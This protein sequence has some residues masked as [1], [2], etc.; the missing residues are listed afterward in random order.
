MSSISYIKQAPHMHHPSV[1]A[2]MLGATGSEEGGYLHGRAGR[3]T[4]NRACSAPGL[5]GGQSC[6]AVP[7]ANTCWRI[8]V[9]SMVEDARHAASSL[10]QTVS[11]AWQHG[12][13]PEKEFS[14]GMRAG[15]RPVA[16]PRQV[17]LLQ[18][19]TPLGCFEPV[20]GIGQR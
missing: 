17:Q 7:Y 16:T 19:G 18:S 13:H 10:R 14:M 11:K 2:D 20:H 15:P 8:Q 6:L 4:G 3:R 1:H 12:G 9:S 5:H